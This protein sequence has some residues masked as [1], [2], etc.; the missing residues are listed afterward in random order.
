MATKTM[1][2]HS[3]LKAVLGVLSLV[4]AIGLVAAIYAATP[5][6][7]WL[8][9]LSRP[10]VTSK[11]AA[12]KAAPAAKVT[13]EPSEGTVTMTKAELEKTIELAVSQGFDKGVEAAQQ[14]QTQERQS[15]S[16]EDAKQVI[17]DYYQ[18]CSRADSTLAESY[19]TYQCAGTINFNQMNPAQDDC[20]WRPVKWRI[21]AFERSGATSRANVLL[22]N[23]NHLETKVEDKAFL[24]LSLVNQE[25][26][27][28]WKI[29]HVSQGDAR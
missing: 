6:D 27:E 23:K 24:I 14:V 22:Q 4:M 13:K 11:H 8:A 17:N 29:A 15:A 7:T 21:V 1:S 2:P 10:T 5:G 12:V 28:R 25:D 16:D 9:R 26:G 20:S 18:A 19:L 3:G